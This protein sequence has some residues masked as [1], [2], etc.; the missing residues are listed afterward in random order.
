MGS[1]GWRQSP[2]S[3][4]LSLRPT[5]VVRKLSQVKEITERGK[6]KCS[7][8]QRK[9]T[10]QNWRLLSFTARKQRNRFHSSSSKASKKSHKTYGVRPHRLFAF[11]T[12]PDG[13]GPSTPSLPPLT[14]GPSAGSGGRLFHS[15]Q[16]RYAVGN[17]ARPLAEPN[18]IKEKTSGL[19]FSAGA[20][21]RGPAQPGHLRQTIKFS[22][23]SHS[24][25][26]SSLMTSG[27]EY[28]G[29]ARLRRFPHDS[30]I[31]GQKRFPWQIK[32]Q[33]SSARGMLCSAGVSPTWTMGKQV[34]TLH[35][36]LVGPP[37]LRY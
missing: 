19:D 27:G 15:N 29:Q 1:R 34:L 20:A 11:A 8:R 7:N 2:L 18:V 28:S 30:G 9:R 31:S 23:I 22:G 16:D 33:W 13:D 35:S 24:S 5:R 6:T 36:P 37:C 17:A 25:L 32:V 10:L 3:H 12:A 4:P 21:R 26:C 14:V